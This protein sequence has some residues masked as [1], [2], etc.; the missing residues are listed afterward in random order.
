MEIRGPLR[1]AGRPAIFIAGPAAATHAMSRR[2]LRS[3]RKSTGTGLAYP[4]R[5]G[6]RVIN[7]KA[8]N[9]IVPIRSMCLNGLSVTRPNCQAVLSPKNEQRSHAP[10]H[11]K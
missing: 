9:K 5:K 7:S 4:K 11:E 6:D 8:G 2:G 10:L 3:A 1:H